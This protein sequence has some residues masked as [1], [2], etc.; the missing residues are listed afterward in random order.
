M[1]LIAVCFCP[2]SVGQRV[3][4]LCARRHEDV[5]LSLLLRP[6]GAE[7]LPKLLSQRDAWVFGQ[8]G[9]LG[10]GVEQLPR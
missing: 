4:Q 2:R 5:V 3:S 9:R 7:A 1:C 6:S 8:P 10:H